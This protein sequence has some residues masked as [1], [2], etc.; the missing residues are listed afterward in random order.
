MTPHS[1][2]SRSAEELRIDQVLR[3]AL[4]A[5]PHF[6]DLAHIGLREE[7]NL[8][9]STAIAWSLRTVDWKSRNALACRVKRLIW[10]DIGAQLTR[11]RGKLF[12]PSEWLSSYESKT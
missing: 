4:R 9:K 3:E 5:V 8:V 7:G 12:R 1:S 11:T 10:L 2:S 6:D